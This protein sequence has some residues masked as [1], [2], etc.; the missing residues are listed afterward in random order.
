MHDLVFFCWW[1]SART[2][3]LFKICVWLYIYNNRHASF[4]FFFLFPFFF[5]WRT[6]ANHRDSI[7]CRQERANSKCLL[8]QKKEEREEREGQFAFFFFVTNHYIPFIQKI[9]SYWRS[10]VIYQSRKQNFFL[11]FFFFSLFVSLS[12]SLCY[13][14]RAKTSIDSNWM[15]MSSLSKHSDLIDRGKNSAE[16]ISFCWSTHV[17][18]ISMTKNKYDTKINLIW[19]RKRKKNFDSH[20]WKTKPF[21]PLKCEAYQ[22]SS[23]FISSGFF[24]SYEKKRKKLHVFNLK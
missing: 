7:K 22:W 6:A 8:H 10:T 3:R 21:C 18:W 24:L 16:I 1:N 19:K 12:L 9:D 4:V 17:Y 20:D 2:W 5:S 14:P 13:N 11:F 23:S 15:P